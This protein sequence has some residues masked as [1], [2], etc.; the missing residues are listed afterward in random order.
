MA[1][2]TTGAQRYQHSLQHSAAALHA[3]QAA[4]AEASPLAALHLRLAQK[5]LGQAER[6]YA[7][8]HPHRAMYLLG[9]A[10]ADAQLALALVQEAAARAHAEELSDRLTDLQGHIQVKDGSTA[11]EQS[12][13]EGALAPINVHTDGA[14]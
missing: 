2:T 4:Q 7:E 14:L 8:G 12:L 3:A 10:E 5:Q 11:A 13:P 6:L 1:C 9:R